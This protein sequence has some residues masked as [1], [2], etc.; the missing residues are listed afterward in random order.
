MKELAIQAWRIAH[1]I[2][3]ANTKNKDPEL[4]ELQHT[5]DQLAIKLASKAGLNYGDFD[6]E[7]C[8]RGFATGN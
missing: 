3:G 4:A 2:G 5:A 7:E 6:H 8:T 1:A